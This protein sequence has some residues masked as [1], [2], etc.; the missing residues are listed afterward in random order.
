MYN[1]LIYL[2]ILIIF[3]YVIFLAGKA[4]SR[5]IEAKDNSKKKIK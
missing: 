2:L 4:V 1:N 5:G 3:I